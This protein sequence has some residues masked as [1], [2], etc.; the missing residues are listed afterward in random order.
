[1]RHEPL[2][3]C[4]EGE[5]ALDWTVVIDATAPA[6]GLS[7]F[8]DNVM[9]P[10]VSCGVHTHHDNW[11][12]YYIVSGRGVLTL[13]GV[14]YDVGPGDISGVYSGGSHG[15]VNTGTEELRFIVIAG[16]DAQP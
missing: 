3:N 4:H 7:F 12:Y 6:G 9:A 5:G 2:P 8:H 1:M 14:E 13:D 15:L 11:E 10:G 16:A